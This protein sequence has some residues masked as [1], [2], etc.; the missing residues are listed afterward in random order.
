MF[1]NDFKEKQSVSFKTN[2]TNHSE[3]IA[4]AISGGSGGGSGG[5]GGAGGGSGGGGG[6]ATGGGDK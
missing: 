2:T 4:T 1:T 5:G 3:I 6:G